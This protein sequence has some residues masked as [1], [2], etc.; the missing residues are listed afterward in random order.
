MDRDRSSG[1][2]LLLSISFVLVICIL[3]FARHLDDNT[4]TNWRWAFNGSVLA[5]LLPFIALGTLL[6]FFV[7]KFSGFEKR[8]RLF[9]FLLTFVF[10]LPLWTAPEAILDVSRYFVEAKYLELHGTRFFLSEWG[11]GIDVWTDMPVA[12]FFYGL[13]FKY[14]GENRLF[15]QLF[16]SLLFSFT[17]LLTY[18]I[19][20]SLWDAEKGF[21]AGLLLLG[22][23]YLPTQVP[24]MLADI[25][26]MFLFTLAIFTY[27]K[28]L[29]SGNPFWTVSSAAA[30][31]LAVFAKYS[32]LLMLTVLPVISFALVKKNFRVVLYRSITVLAVAG[33]LSLALILAKYDVF[34]GQIEL[35][36]N[37]QLP[38]LKRWH[39]SYLS[40]FLFQTHPFVSLSAA[41]AVYAAVTKMDK[42]F[43]VAGWFAVLVFAFRLERI[44]YIV[45][46]FPLFALMASYGLNELRNPRLKR[47]IAFGVVA[48]SLAVLMGAYLPFLNKM[49]AANLQ[50]AGKYLDTLKCETI[51]VHTIPQAGS[52]G[53]TKVAIPILDLFTDKRLVSLQEFA[54]GPAGKSI[55]KLPLRF[56]WEFKLP[57]FYRDGNAA[58]GLPAAVISS[59]KTRTPPA[60]IK[61]FLNSDEVL[62]EFTISSGRF[63]YK[64]FVTIFG[65]DC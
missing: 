26:A 40:T 15:I 36:K 46:L 6:S 42:R 47:F 27:M 51:R 48:S 23:P 7:S 43:L 38:G 59:V 19:G 41:Y 60:R 11:N 10:V 63:R 20:R 35:L 62:K 37:F 9:L 57:G 18:S 1:Q 58:K 61:E 22:I 44:R 64:T 32:L 24:L 33:L 50:D 3:Y 28:T 5:R 2:I 55:E 8:P 17:V 13:I 34:A 4:L 29:E 49:S 53:S 31:F 21:Y 16:N 14:F 12:P 30:I 65:K 56:T 25:P 45:P 52:S 39:E 54:S